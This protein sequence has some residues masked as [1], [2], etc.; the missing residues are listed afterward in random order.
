MMVTEP[1]EVGKHIREFR[2]AAGISLVLLA[3]RSKLNETVVKNVER[4]VHEPD[5][6]SVIKMAHSLDLTLAEVFR[7][8]TQ[9][10]E[11]PA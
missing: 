10:T 1:G 7:G 11:R 6:V 8:A 3:S 4:G 9:G 5:S 2:E